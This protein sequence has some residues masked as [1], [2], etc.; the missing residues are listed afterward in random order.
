MS[1]RTELN[2][3]DIINWRKQ[4]LVEIRNRPGYWRVVKELNVFK[5]V[6]TYLS[7]VDRDVVV[8]PHLKMTNILYHGHNSSLTENYYS[9]AD[10]IA[11]LIIPVG[12]EIYID[13]WK[14]TVNP[15]FLKMRASQAQVH[16]IV[17]ISDK[18]QV[19]FARSNY[20]KLFTYVNP[21]L[22]AGADKVIHPGN[23]WAQRSGQCAGG[24][25]FYI[26]I[27]AALSH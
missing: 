4:H 27:D 24:I 26:N 23:G 16:S 18:K 20:D 15:D 14:A 9:R 8:N 1:K 6:Q 25:H 22:V 5:K 3:N 12:S 2:Y 11:N 13:D 7:G 19:V 17:R 21:Q 10:A